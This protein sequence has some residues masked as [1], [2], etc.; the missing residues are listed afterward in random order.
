MLSCSL[1]YVYWYCV[2][3]CVNLCSAVWTI[4]VSHAFLSRNDIPWRHHCVRAVL[5]FNINF[6]HMHRCHFINLGPH[7]DIIVFALSCRLNNI[8]MH[9]CN[10]GT[11][12]KYLFKKKIKTLAHGLLAYEGVTSYK[13]QAR[14]L[15]KCPPPLVW[16]WHFLAKQS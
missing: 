15:Y 2:H 16:N 4:H 7:D 10:Q 6:I 3:I 11:K 1:F 13:W 5:H 8:P 12:P 9:I 14:N